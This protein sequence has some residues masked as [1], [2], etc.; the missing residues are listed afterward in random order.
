MRDKLL[1]GEIFYSSKEA[2]VIIKQWG[3]HYNQV[4]FHSALGYQTPSPEAIIPTTSQ[5][6]HAGV[7]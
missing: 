6:Q 3:W 5:P 1:A 4:G 7:A 2:K